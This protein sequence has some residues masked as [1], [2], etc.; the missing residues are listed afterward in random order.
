MNRLE[1]HWHIST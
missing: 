1:N